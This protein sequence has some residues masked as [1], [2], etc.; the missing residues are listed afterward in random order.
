MVEYQLA[1][2]EGMGGS[3]DRTNG[4]SWKLFVKSKEWDIHRSFELQGQLSQVY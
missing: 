3:Q 1:V 4:V 2:K